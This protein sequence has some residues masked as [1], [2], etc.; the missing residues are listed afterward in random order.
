VEL[1]DEGRVEEAVKSW[2]EAHNEVVTR[3]VGWTRKRTG[4]KRSWYDKEVGK[5]NEDM[6][7]VM[8]EWLKEEDGERKV[9]LGERR[10]AIRRERQRAVRRKRTKRMVERMRLMESAGASGKGEHLLH[11]LQEWSGKARA[12]VGGDRK[13]MVNAEGDRFEG[14]AMRA[15]W[16]DTFE[17]VGKKLEAAAGGVR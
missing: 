12:L 8:E 2:L 9:E 14:E 1:V 11:L 17:S 4:P 6:R 5:W 10:K 16:R 3:S 7:K 15:K 13:W